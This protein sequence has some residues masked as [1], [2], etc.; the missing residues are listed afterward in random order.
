M[1][2][3]KKVIHSN[4]QTAIFSW[5]IFKLVN[6]A[7]HLI[8]IARAGCGKTYT[9]LEAIFRFLL[10]NPKSSVLYG[11]F[12]K[13]NQREAVDKATAA[14]PKFIQSGSL[15]ISTWHSVGFK[16]ISQAWGRIKASQYAEWNRA[17]IVCPEIEQKKY[18]M[19][20]VANLVSIAKNH[21][22]GVPTIDEMIKLANLK[23]IETNKNDAVL[24]PVE[25]LAEIAIK[26][27]EL[28]KERAFEISFDDMVW[29]PVACDMVKP[30]FDL[31]V[32]DEAQ[33]LSLNQFAILEKL[34]KP[35]GRICLVGD[36]KQAIYG[37]RGA[38][39]GGLDIMREKL[40]AQILPLTTTFRCPKKVVEKSRAFAPDYQ[41]HESN[42]EGEILACD[43]KQILD[44]AQVSDCIL[45]RVNAPLMRLCLRFIQKGKPAKIEGKD[46][47]RGLVNL[48]ES[49]NATDL[50]D[51]TSKLE[52]WQ[53]V[54]TGKATGKNA[55]RKIEFIQDQAETIRAL[56]EVCS[57]VSQLTFK[58]N[59]LFQDSQSDYARPCVL[60]SSVHKAKGLE[61]DR[62][63]ILNETFY[64]SHP[65]MTAEEKEQE[66]HIHYVALTRT[67]ETLIEVSPAI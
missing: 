38:V 31:I 26:I 50:T 40:Q 19:A 12:N 60:L 22:L 16:I 67:K 63:F 25:R 34:V 55:A 13:K 48:I 2:T 3:T 45:S 8:V 32:G 46:I 58:L 47:A 37:F 9:I 27:M 18:I 7:Q 51:L 24:W 44:Q 20:L 33:D 52:S 29:L 42:L 21:C 23:G 53:T 56:S 14:F 1:Q 61:W 41:A 4:E 59:D 62:V 6:Q 65:L 43:D 39:C 11:V 30:S 17:K 35:G 15:T 5:F 54:A 64:C 66:K 57:T 28:S 10:D 49:L 36:D